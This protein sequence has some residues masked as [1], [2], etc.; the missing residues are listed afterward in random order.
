[1]TLLEQ[2]DRIFAMR[3]EQ[4]PRLRGSCEG[5]LPAEKEHDGKPFRPEARTVVLLAFENRFASLG[6]LTPVMNYL[7]RQLVNMGERVLFISPFHSRHP[8]MK[9]A[10]RDGILK[11]IFVKTPFQLAGY[12]A[13]F[14]CYRDT[15]AGIPSYY[16]GIPDR[17]CAGD[18]PYGYSGRGKL[19]KD[20]LAFA[21]AVPFACAKLGFSENVLFHAHEWETAP[22]AVT[23]KLAGCLCRARTVLTLHNSFDCGISPA[24]KR[25][26]FG[27]ELPGDTVL[28]CSAPFLCGPLVTVS[29]P[30]ARELSHDPLQRGFFADH[31]QG[32]FSKNPP[33]GI[34]NG[35]FS[36]GA[37]PF[38]APAL[39][40][41][42]NGSYEKLLTRKTTYR[43]RFLKIVERGRDSRSIGKLTIDHNDTSTPV[44]LMTGR[45]DFMQKGFDVMFTA[46][47]RLKRGRAKLFFCPSV[48]SGKN[49]IDL[50]FFKAITA[51]CPGDIEIWPFK[52]RRRVYDL[53]LRGSSYLLMPSLYEPF[54]SAN[55]GLLSGTPAVA[56]ATGG[57]WVQVNSATPVA[58]PTFYSRLKLDGRREFPTGIL[59]RE[60][61][62]DEKAEKEWRRLLELPLARRLKVPL[63]L[64]LMRS[65]EAALKDACGIFA[66]PEEYARLIVNGLDEVKK[67]SW[68]RAA[69]KYMQVYDVACTRGN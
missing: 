56:R 32:I 65:A 54:G 29:T 30:F 17:F 38:S 19:L 27:T 44:F 33:V 16:L 57:L 40:A 7:P 24:E 49:D 23:S 45:L 58:V 67:L 48:T 2:F 4:W 68:E 66:R 59:F 60:K 42:R 47:E 21:A 36:E 20:A 10:H 51:R 14:S 5:I 41:A 15:L 1:M 25:L 50:D 55:E 61:Y 53:F 22:V 18:N 31:L 62:P 46:F 28:Q 12:G 34:E 8:A 43:R 11:K 3:L 9:A 37:S 6:G 63:F 39:Q 26:F 13:V 64:S 35:V 52:I 69:K